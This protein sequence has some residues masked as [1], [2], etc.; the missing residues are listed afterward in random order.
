[1]T[2]PLVFSFTGKDYSA[3]PI[4]LSTIHQFFTARQAKLTT[5][6]IAPTF[7]AFFRG[8]VLALLFK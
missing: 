4:S 1:M 7:S 6:A 2:V 5:S 8:L 3:G